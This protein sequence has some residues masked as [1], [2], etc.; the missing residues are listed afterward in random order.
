MSSR[1]CGK[2]P[3]GAEAAQPCRRGPG[4][5][6]GPSENSPR[7]GASCRSAKGRRRSSETSPRTG[8]RC[9][10]EET[11]PCGQ[12]AGPPPRSEGSGRGTGERPP[13]RKLQGGNDSLSLHKVAI[14]KRVTGCS[15]ERGRVLSGVSPRGRLRG[16]Q[17]PLRSAGR[18]P[19]QKALKLQ[20]GQPPLPWPPFPHL[21]DTL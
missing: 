11:V 21:C 17:R 20:L 1:S 15:P 14:G 18:E 4:P 13:C 10:P 12:G 16:A 2:R 3:A 19:S 6:R 7:Q 5:R 8:A 9:G